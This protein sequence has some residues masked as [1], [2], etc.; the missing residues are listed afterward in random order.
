MRRYNRRRDLLFREG[1]EAYHALLRHASAR[2]VEG[3]ISRG[4]EPL[5]R[6]FLPQYSLEKHT[7]CTRGVRGI[8][9]GGQRLPLYYGITMYDFAI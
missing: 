3:E 5:P 8:T 9:L 7:I 4:E 6:A 2:L 1:N